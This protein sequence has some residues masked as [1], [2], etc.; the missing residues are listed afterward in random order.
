MDV[1]MI[2]ITGTIREESRLVAVAEPVSV[3]VAERADPEPLSDV[4]RVPVHPDV[5]DTSVPLPAVRAHVPVP[6]LDRLPVLVPVRV[7]APVV[8][9]PAELP[10]V[11]LEAAEVRSPE[12]R[13]DSEA[14]V[15][16]EELPPTEVP[17]PLV[18]WAEVPVTKS[19]EEPVGEP[20]V[21][22]A[23]ED[24]ESSEEPESPETGESPEETADVPG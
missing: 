18:P 6:V 9:S 23:S 5:I 11:P 10:E 14:D 12:A 24:P 16:E 20:F 21:E 17:E 22:V 3:P 8:V 19:E 2:C 13:D 4:R 1:W 7:P 15:S